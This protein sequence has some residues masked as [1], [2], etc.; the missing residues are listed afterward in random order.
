[1]LRVAREDEQ[2]QEG[3]HGEDGQRLELAGQVGRGALLDRVADALH[4]LGAL[5]GGKHLLP[6]HVGHRERD[7][8]DHGDDDDERDIAAGQGHVHAT[9]RRG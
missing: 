7:E 3:D 8:G 2:Q 1:M 4:V 5:V 9:V 6:E